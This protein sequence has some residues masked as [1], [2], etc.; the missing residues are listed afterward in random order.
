L[1]IQL[2]VN[3]QTLQSSN[4][5]QMIFTVAQLVSY[6]SVVFTLEP[7]DLIFTGTPPGIG[8]ARNPAV[9]LKP[10]DVAEVEI[11]SLG[12]LRNPIIAE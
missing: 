2:R 8:H 4:T 5:G 11:Q 6:L 3:G 10:G 7:G 12:L 1:D 9:Y